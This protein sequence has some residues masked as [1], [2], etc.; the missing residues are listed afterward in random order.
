MNRQPTSFH[1]FCGAGGASLGFQRAGFRS[2]GAID[3]DPIACLDHEILTG[4][5]GTWADIMLMSPED[6]CAM[7][8]CETPDVRCGTMEI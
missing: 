2:L 4:E 6:L 1:L 3:N 8:D 5:K 7:T